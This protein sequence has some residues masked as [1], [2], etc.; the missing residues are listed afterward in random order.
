[1]ALGQRTR[2]SHWTSTTSRRITGEHRPGG[3]N[4]SPEPSSQS[5]TSP[6]SAH[7]QNAAPQRSTAP[8]RIK[9]VG[10]LGVSRSSMG[11]V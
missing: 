5:F 10:Q 7:F 2:S 3:P 11:G 8:M 1:M 6:H 4:T 9:Q